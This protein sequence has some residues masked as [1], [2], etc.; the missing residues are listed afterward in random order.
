MGRK[1]KT[2]REEV[3]EGLRRLALGDIKD[4]VLLLF[5]REDDIIEK[6]PKMNLYNVSEIKRPKGGGMEIKFFDRIRALEK[7]REIENSN[8]SESFSFYNAL[9]EGAKNLNSIYQGENDE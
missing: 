9:E 7:L 6:L 1:K 3:Q 8:T 2:V 4:A 5:A